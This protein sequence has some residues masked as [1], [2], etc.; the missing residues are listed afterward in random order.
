MLSDQLTREL[1][2]LVIN[3]AQN[4]LL[5]NFELQGGL[6]SHDGYRWAYLYGMKN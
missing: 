2:G 4:I 5:V 1:D 6:S 3:G